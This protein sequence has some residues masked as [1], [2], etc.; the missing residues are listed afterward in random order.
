M[1]AWNYL[2]LAGFATLGICFIAY[3]LRVN[4]VNAKRTEARAAPQGSKMAPIF[5][6]ITYALNEMNKIAEEQMKLGV[7]E[8]QL[9]PLKD[10][11]NKLKFAKD[12][13]GLILPI[14]DGAMKYLGKFV[15]G[16]L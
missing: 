2:G 4:A 8:A 6:G 7:T 10:R 13:E 5:E 3:N 16:I 12:H 14:A 1:I 9:K 11:Y 15:K